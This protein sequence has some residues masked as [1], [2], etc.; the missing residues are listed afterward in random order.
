M[1]GVTDTVVVLV[2]GPDR[3]VLAKLARTLVAEHLIACLNIVP[4]VTSIYRWDGEVREEREALGFIKTTAARADD[5]VRRISELHPYDTPEI[6]VLP[7]EGGSR[8]YLDWV[9]TQVNP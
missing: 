3:D 6:L 4:E 7:V 9:R 2:T 8:A 5:V 1:T